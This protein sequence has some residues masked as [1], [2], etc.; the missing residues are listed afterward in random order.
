MGFRIEKLPAGTT[1][2]EFYKGLKASVRSGKLPPGWEIEWQWR[3]TPG[4]K[5]LTDEFE[6]TIRESRGGWADLMLLTIDNLQA[7]RGAA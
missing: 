3:N 4:G 5:Q 1:E 2:A 6:K 7:K